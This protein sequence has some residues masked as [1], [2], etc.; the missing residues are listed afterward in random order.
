MILNPLIRLKLDYPDYYWALDKEN[1]ATTG[2]VSNAMPI[3]MEDETLFPLADIEKAIALAGV[4]GETDYGGC[5]PIAEMGI[6][7][8]FVR[9]LNYS[10][11]IDDPSN[12]DKRI[13]LA[14]DV[15]SNTH[16]SLFG[17]KNQ[18]LVWPWDAA[19]AFNKVIDS[20]GLG[21]QIVAKDSWTLFGGKKEDYWKMIVENINEGIPVTL[22]TGMECGGGEFSKH[23]TNIYG[24]ETWVGFANQGNEKM[25][26]RFIKARLN[27]GRKADAYCDAGILDCAQVGLISYEVNYDTLYDFHASDFSRDFVNGDGGGQ[28]FFLPKESDVTLPNGTTIKTERLRTSYIENK[29]LVMSPNREGAASAYLDVTFPHNVSRLSFDSSMW[30]SKEGAVRESFEIQYYK[31]DHFESQISI[32]PNKLSISKEHPDNFVVLLPENTKR[33][34]FFSYH[35]NPIAD[36]NK[37]RI[38]LDNF[39]VSYH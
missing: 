1:S 12:S 16:F 35:S 11:I 38:C 26:K 7:D 2:G 31:D 23:Y 3:E 25:I 10:E 5:G 33:I 39:S 30:S 22:F 32:D 29:Y 8:Y 20:R 18:T 17:S 36:R 15:L 27:W 34:R 21:N 28:Y 37:G 4:E 19:N 14:K 13:E 9:Y 6:L 24:Y